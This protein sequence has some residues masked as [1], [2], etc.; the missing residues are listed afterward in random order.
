VA[1]TI[2]EGYLNSRYKDKYGLKEFDGASYLDKIVQLPFHIPPHRGRME[3]FLA[4]LLSQ[5]DPDVQCVFDNLKHIIG[6]AS[7]ANP[8]ATKRFVNNLLIDR[9]INEN[10][11]RV[12]IPEHARMEVIPIAYF[13]VTRSLQQRWKEVFSQLAASP[14]LCTQISEWDRESVIEHANSEDHDVSAVATTLLG[15]KAIAELLFSSEGRAWL[16]DEDQRIS[17]IEFLKEKR[18]EATGQMIRPADE[19]D[20]FISYHHHDREPVA[21][22][23][24]FLAD[25]GIKF[26]IDREQIE[27]GDL[28]AE[29]I[30][31]AMAKSRAFIVCVGRGLEAPGWQASEMDTALRQSGKDRDLKIIPILLPGADPE[32]LPLFLKT[33]QW[34]DLRDTKI[35]DDTLRPLARALQYKT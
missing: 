24:N 7:G 15:D 33:R 21:R 25:R 16:K 13:A 34:L 17:T 20:V 22:I 14:E 26:F 9:A 27:A 1:R 8:R 4:N 30:D 2:I 12:E 10:L 32:R 11:S 6:S 35:T 23:A 19:F 3:A 5:L 18:V 31:Q 28:W 29:K